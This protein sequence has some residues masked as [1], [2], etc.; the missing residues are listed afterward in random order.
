L[1]VVIER[2]VQ[3]GDAWGWGT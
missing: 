2:V 1:L 3:E